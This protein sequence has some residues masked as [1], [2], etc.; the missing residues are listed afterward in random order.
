MISLSVALM[1][2]LV[3][4]FPGGILRIQIKIDKAIMN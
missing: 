4:V 2:Q 1:I 3:I